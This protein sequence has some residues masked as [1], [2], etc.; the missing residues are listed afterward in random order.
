MIVLTLNAALILALV[1]VGLFA[2]SV[3]VLAAAGDTLGD[4]LGLVIGLIAVSLRDRNPDH[5]HA[6]RPIAIAALVNAC[7]LII[8][9]V[10]V[11]VE[12]IVRLAEGIPTVYGLPVVVVSVITV[13]VMLVGASV[14]GFAA[15]D[16][17]I[18]MRSVLLDALADAAAA[19]GVTIAGAIILISGGLYWLDPVLALAISAFIGIAAA[20]LGLKAIGALRG[21]A[22]EFH[23]N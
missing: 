5:P 22:A 17:D 9:A 13:V 6:Q 11:V 19:A 14:L 12:S 4:C 8:V 18:H 3:S 20:R 15:S 2:H 7:L 21:R 16:E 1:T 23:D 10:S